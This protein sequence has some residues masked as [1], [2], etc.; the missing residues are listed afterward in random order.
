MISEIMIYSQKFAKANSSVYHIRN[1][2]TWFNIDY[3]SFVD[4]KSRDSRV[5]LFKYCYSTSEYY[6]LVK[7]CNLCNL[8]IKGWRDDCL[9]VI[10]SK[11]KNLN[12]NIIINLRKNYK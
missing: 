1:Y 6:E 2:F 5:F 9:I 10:E 3:I 11:N 8:N 7:F 12:K 4:N